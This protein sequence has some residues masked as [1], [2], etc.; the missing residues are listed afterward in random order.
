M[1]NLSDKTDKQKTHDPYEEDSME[2]H[3]SKYSQSYIDLSN[4]RIIFLNEDFTKST[5]SEMTALLLHYDKQSQDDIYIYINSQGGD[6]AALSNIYDVMGLI[7]SPITTICMGK[8]FSAGAFLLMAGNT[9]LMFKHAECMLHG[10]QVVFPVPSKEHTIDS[11]DY[12]KYL[13][14]FND[15]M[16]KMAAKATGKTLKQIKQDCIMDLYMTSYEALAYGLIDA[17]IE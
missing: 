4:N 10:A 3:P 5:A 15:R 12:A 7:A 1:I 13:D 17:I 8:A 16:L 2:L 11:D 9:R 14:K 6:A